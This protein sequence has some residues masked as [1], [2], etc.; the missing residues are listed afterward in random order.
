MVM[1]NATGVLLF[2]QVAAKRSEDAGLNVYH[3]RAAADGDLDDR[4]I[5][6]VHVRD[7][8]KRE[9]RRAVD[10]RIECREWVDVD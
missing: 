8:V 4:R 10:H 2:E 6:R 1:V 9:G 5:A 7:H 3:L